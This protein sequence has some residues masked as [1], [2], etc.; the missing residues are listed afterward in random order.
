MHT[1]FRGDIMYN[2]EVDV[3]LPAL[4][5]GDTLEFAARARVPSVI[6]RGFTSK[7]FACILRDV[8][9]AMF[10]I[11]HTINSK[12]G[13]DFV[14]GVSGGER[15]RVSIAEAALV[16]AKLQCWDNSTR[17]LD[18]DNAISFCETLRVQ[19][20]VMDIA[21]IVAIYQAP[22]SAYAVRPSPL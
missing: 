22:Q 2:A 5:V 14:R 20:D 7:Q 9:M 8:T 12:V 21:A 15:K 18:S 17:G 19:A 13:D 3:H 10:R 6:P 16:R 4:T 11:T 1:R